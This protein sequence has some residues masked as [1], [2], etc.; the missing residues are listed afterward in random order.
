[1]FRQHWQQAVS[2]TSISESGTDPLYRNGPSI[3]GR[4]RCIALVSRWIGSIRMPSA[5]SGRNWWIFEEG[6]VSKNIFRPLLARLQVVLAPLYALNYPDWVI[7]VFDWVAL[8]RNEFATIFLVKVLPTCDYGSVRLSLG[9]QILK[10]H[11]SLIPNYELRVRND[12]IFHFYIQWMKNS[13]YPQ[14]PC[15]SFFKP[16]DCAYQARIKK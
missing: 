1:M 9:H 16:E 8:R 12:Y 13:P 11:G 10:C 14:S 3:L 6:E 7:D 4:L 15:G 2:A 5:G